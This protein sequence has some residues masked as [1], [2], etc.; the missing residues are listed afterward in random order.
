[1]PKTSQNN[2]NHLIRA[3]LGGSL[4]RFVLRTLALVLSG[5]FPV[6]GILAVLSVLGCPGFGV[7]LLWFLLLLWL[8]LFGWFGL[9][10]ATRAFCEIGKGE[11]N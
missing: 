8:L 4:A 5:I 6:L 9:S 7:T 10:V 1:M 2:R 3:G 11:N